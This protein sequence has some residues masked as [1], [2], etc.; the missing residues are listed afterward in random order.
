MAGFTVILVFLLLG[1]AL[2]LAGIPLPGSVIG[3][4]L[5][6]VSLAAGII[7][8]SWI[9]KSSAFLLKNMAFFFVPAGAGIMAHADM[10]EDYWAPIVFSVVLS[11][12]FVLLSVALT[13]RILKARKAGK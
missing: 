5:L 7:R 3:M 11:F 10:L 6:T 9:E 8:R 12:L 4:L 13:Q 2:H 1:E